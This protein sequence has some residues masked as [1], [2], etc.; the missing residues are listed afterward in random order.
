MAVKVGEFWEQRALRKQAER[1]SHSYG[2]IAKRSVLRAAAG[3]A[4]LAFVLVMGSFHTLS[5]LSAIV[6]ELFDVAASGRSS[7]FRSSGER[8]AW[9]VVPVTVAIAS[10]MTFALFHILRAYYL[11]CRWV[12][13]QETPTCQMCGYD[14]RGT[15]SDH[16][17]ECGGAVVAPPKVAEE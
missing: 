2:R 4:V 16:C 15:V 13:L 5:C 12:Y 9:L 1:Q 7:E 17:S 8:R 14:S 3:T 6:V 11:D 10:A